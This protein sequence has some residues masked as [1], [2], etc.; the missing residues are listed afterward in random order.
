MAREMLRNPKV[1]I[2]DECTSA[3]DVTSAK[4]INDIIGSRSLAPVTII[5]SHQKETIK[6]CD[7]IFFLVD[8]TVA[9]MGTYEELMENNWEF[10]K[11]LNL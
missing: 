5:V 6:L 9:M 4:K 2:L 1:L 8:G 10:R 3:L 7:K 11:L